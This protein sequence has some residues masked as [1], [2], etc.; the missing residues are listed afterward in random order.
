M[1][2]LMSSSRFVCWSMQVGPWMKV[3]LTFHGWHAYTEAFKCHILVNLWPQSCV[4]VI[5]THLKGCLA[6]ATHTF[7]WV[8][9]IQICQI[10]CPVIV[11]LAD[12]RQVPALKGAEQRQ[13]LSNSIYFITN[14]AKIRGCANKRIRTLAWCWLSV[15]LDGPTFN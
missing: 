13:S 15:V 11:L 4:I 14:G 9:I 5:Y 3:G 10:E 1:C 6:D 8:K 12:L 2:P 7:K